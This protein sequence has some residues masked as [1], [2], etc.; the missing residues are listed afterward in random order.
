MSAVRPQVDSQGQRGLHQLGGDALLGLQLGPPGKN[1]REKGDQPRGEEDESGG[2]ACD[3]QAERKST[4]PAYQH[5]LLRRVCASIRVDLA[6]RFR[7][8]APP[9]NAPGSY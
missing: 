4:H 2:E 3:L 5:P 8:R 7:E 9:P 6:R 1:Y